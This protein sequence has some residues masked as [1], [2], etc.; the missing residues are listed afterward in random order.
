M[1]RTHRRPIFL[2]EPGLSLR[3]RG[4]VKHSLGRLSNSIALTGATV[5]KGGIRLS[6]HALANLEQF[7]C[8]KIGQERAEPWSK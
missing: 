6:S 1:S 3:I 4:A 2:A 5:F 7:A 8:L